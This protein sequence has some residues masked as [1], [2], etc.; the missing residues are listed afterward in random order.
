MVMITF[1]SDGYTEYFKAIK[2]LDLPN[3][4]VSMFTMGG[5]SYFTVIPISSV[6]H[7]RRNKTQASAM[8]AREGDVHRF[9]VFDDWGSPHT[10]LIPD[11]E[12]RREII[13]DNIKK[14]EAAGLLQ[15]TNTYESN[16]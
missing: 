10:L 16:R 13:Q 14:L 12:A 5:G 8:Y 15:S 9:Q 3:G 2:R 4:I 7:R 11:G 1:H 6:A